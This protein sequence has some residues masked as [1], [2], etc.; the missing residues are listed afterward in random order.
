VITSFF[1]IIEPAGAFHRGLSAEVIPLL[2]ARNRPFERWKKL[3]TIA[4]DFTNK[5]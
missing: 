3:R 4:D 2:L 1:L 5:K